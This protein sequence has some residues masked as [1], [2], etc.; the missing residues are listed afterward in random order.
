[1]WFKDIIREVVFIRPQWLTKLFAMIEMQKHKGKSTLQRTSPD[2]Y[3]MLTRQG[4]L[5]LDLLKVLWKHDKSQCDPSRTLSK[6]DESNLN[7]IP[8]DKL[9][10]LMCHFEVMREVSTGGHSEPIVAEVASVASA[11]LS[12]I[13]I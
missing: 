6:V 13:H 9:V 8:F 12:L 3:R 1:M 4:L 2:G 7:Q 10:L 5:R 11:T